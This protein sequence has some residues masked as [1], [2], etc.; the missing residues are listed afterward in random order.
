MIGKIGLA[1]LL[2]LICLGAQAQPV[3]AD[4]ELHLLL[5]ERENL[6]KDYTYYN[7]QN[8]NFWGKKSKKDLL[9][10]VETLKSIIKKDSKIIERVS[11]LNLKK[12]AELA[13]QEQKIETRVIDD[14]QTLQDRMHQL[15]QEAENL[16]NL[17]KNRQRR[18]GELEEQL[19]EARQNRYEHDR[20]T[21]IALVASVL[22]VAYV[23]YLQ[24]KLRLRKVRKG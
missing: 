3:P 16:Q 5:R 6:V 22:L 2:L 12:E 11:A 9:D 23:L 21:I 4:P 7:A 14:R 15:N 19:Q 13:V 8:S 10:I 1:L 17:S 18:I 20:L 24:S